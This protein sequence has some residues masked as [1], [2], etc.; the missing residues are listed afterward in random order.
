MPS[1]PWNVTEATSSPRSNKRSS[2]L[3]S[4]WARWF[5]VPI[6][7]LPALSPRVAYWRSIKNSRAPVAL[8]SASSRATACWYNGSVSSPSE[9]SLRY[10]GSRIWVA[11]EAAIASRRW[12]SSASRSRRLT[13]Y[14]TTANSANSATT[15]T[16]SAASSLTRIV[17]RKRTVPS[18]PR[19]QDHEHQEEHSCDSTDDDPLT[20]RREVALHEH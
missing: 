2:S 16:T 9:S 14:A 1:L 7:T 19:Y 12:P 6:S 10:F 3:R 4:S 11:A 8:P 15:G 13:S 20:G 5:S 18:L 17:A